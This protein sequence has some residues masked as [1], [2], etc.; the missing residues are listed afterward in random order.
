MGPAKKIADVARVVGPSVT[1]D[2]LYGISLGDV[3]LAGELWTEDAF[4]YSTE[5][6]IYPCFFF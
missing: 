1:K 4:I 5:V 3:M 6:C 2:I